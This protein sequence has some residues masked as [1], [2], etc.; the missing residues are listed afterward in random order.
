VIS[1]FLSQ[2][3]NEYTSQLNSLKHELST[4]LEKNEELTRLLS[5][6]H[7]L[8]SNFDKQRNSFPSP[9]MTT[10]VLTR[11]NTSPAVAGTQFKTVEAFKKLF[12]SQDF[13]PDIMIK[14]GIELDEEDPSKFIDRIAEIKRDRDSL[15][16][17]AEK[18][19]DLINEL[20]EELEED[21]ENQLLACVIRL[22][23]RG[24]DND[25]IN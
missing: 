2:S 20:K 21:N 7:Y 23:G 1:D 22:K 8:Y 5:C 11:Q 6:Q 12:E 19:E 24:S 13:D 3:Q 4:A 16:L 18:Y 25:S 9:G 17:A 15:Y 14:I 10:R